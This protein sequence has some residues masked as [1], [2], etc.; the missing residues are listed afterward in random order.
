MSQVFPKILDYICGPTG[1]P[2]NYTEFE[3]TEG[4]RN[5]HTFCIGAEE[6]DLTLD[7]L[8]STITRLNLAMDYYC[9]IDLNEVLEK[10]KDVKELFL[11]IKHFANL[12]T[13]EQAIL[14][15]KIEVL[16]FDCVK[17]VHDLEETLR[18]T[19]N[20]FFCVDEFQEHHVLTDLDLFQESEVVT[21]STR[22]GTVVFWYRQLWLTIKTFL[23]IVRKVPNKIDFFSYNV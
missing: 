21:A 22:Y 7:N 4:V 3:S 2:S 17:W 11:N 13:F 5:E 15:S 19:K 18:Y 1:L 6:S 9:T 14:G 8:Q 16:I 23:T 12:K 20:K 10:C